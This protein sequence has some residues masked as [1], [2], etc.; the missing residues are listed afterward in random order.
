MKGLKHI[1]QKLVRYPLNETGAVPFS[2]LLLAVAL[3][4]MLVRLWVG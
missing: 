4:A 2:I 3:I 1:T